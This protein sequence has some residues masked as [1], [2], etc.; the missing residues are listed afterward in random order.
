CGHR[1]EPLAQP[2]LDVL[3]MKVKRQGPIISDEPSD[4]SDGGVRKSGRQ[5][6]ERNLDFGMRFKE[7]VTRRY[8]D[9]GQ[10]QLARDVGVGKQSPT[11][12]TRGTMPAGD[13][14]FRVADA[15]GV[16]AR[17][18]ATGIGEAGGQVAAQGDDAGW[19]RL[20]RLDLFAFREG[21]RPDPVEQVPIR[22]DWLAMAARSSAP[23]WVAD[24]PSDAMPDVAREGDAIVCREPD[25]PLAD[26]RVYVLLLDGQPIVR[27]VQLRPE[28]VV[29]KAGDPSIDP[30][31][32]AAD[33]L[34]QLVPIGRVLAA[35]TLQAV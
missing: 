4:S 26:G 27:R 2:G 8:G 25:R 9:G 10:A 22:R 6:K 5:P 24:M 31:T 19:V 23:M 16:D 20:P 3:A 15:L 30:I 18:L 7:L 32:L 21:I 11:D 29:L 12:W 35:M 17:W 28:G 13:T 34:D 14:L 1:P 33:R